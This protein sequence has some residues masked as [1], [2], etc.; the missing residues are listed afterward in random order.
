MNR[1]QMLRLM[2]KLNRIAIKYNKYIQ[3]LPLISIMW[4]ML[5]KL[6]NNNIFQRINKI[7]KLIIILNIIFC[8]SLIL[9]F[10][11]F[12]TPL[13]LTYS[14]Y[15]DLLEPYIELIKNIWSQMLNNIKNPISAGPVNNEIGS[16]L[17]ESIN[18]IQS[19]VKSGIK[20]GISPTLA[21]HFTDIEPVLSPVYSPDFSKLGCRFY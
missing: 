16:I 14:I 11:D 8:F 10:T 3:L 20:S 13:N 12:V 1:S 21:K 9:Y 19:E 5:S 4:S 18:Q 17:K 15:N 2:F 6:V 7:I